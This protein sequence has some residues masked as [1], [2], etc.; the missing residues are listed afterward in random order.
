MPKALRYNTGKPELSYLFEAPLAMEG[1]ANRFAL[2]TKKYSRDNWKGGFE[3]DKL[4]DSL[5]RHIMS[6]KNGQSVDEDG[7]NHVDA[8]MWNAV[9]LA[10]QYYRSLKENKTDAA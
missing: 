8:I 9:V 5:T 6:Y 3:T 4:I 1:L 2:G 10:E 7:G